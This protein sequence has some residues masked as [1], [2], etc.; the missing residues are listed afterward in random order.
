MSRL[1]EILPPRLYI[2]VWMLHRLKNPLVVS[3]DAVS[4][5]I[6]STIA[7][8]SSSSSLIRWSMVPQTRFCSVRAADRNPLPVSVGWIGTLSKLKFGAFIICL[9]KL[10]RRTRELLDADSEPAYSQRYS[11]AHCAR[12]QNHA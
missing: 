10:L 1:I 12:P 5:F 8:N 7:M 11:Q 6:S 4:A 9:Q 2:L 3:R